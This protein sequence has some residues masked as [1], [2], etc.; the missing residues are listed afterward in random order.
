[1]HT[2]Q[3]TK[4]ALA[5]ALAEQARRLR[6]QKAACT[7]LLSDWAEAYRTIDG[8]PYNL[9]RY[10]YLRAFYD[11]PARRRCLIKGAQ[12]GATEAM[13]NLILGLMWRHEVQ[14]PGI[15]FLRPTKTEAI[16]FSTA[17]F[18]LAIDQ[19]P[20]LA[21]MFPNADSTRRTSLKIGNGVS[22]YIV[23]GNSRADLKSK[24]CGVLIVDEVDELPEE[25]EDSEQ[26]PWNPLAF[27][28][29][30]L[31]GCEDP[32]EI[33]ASTPTLPDMGIDAAYKDSNQ[34]LYWMPCPKC[35]AMQILEWPKSI[36]WDGQNPDTARFRCVKGCEYTQGEKIDAMPGGEWRARIPVHKILGLSTSQLYSPTVRPEQICE[37][38]QGAQTDLIK[39]QLFH[40]DRL[41]QGHVVKGSRLDASILNAARGSHGLTSAAGAGWR[42]T[43]GL[44]VGAV[45]HWTATNRTG[46]PH[47]VGLGTVPTL[48]DVPAL[49]AQWRPVAAVIDQAPETTKVRDFQKQFG[50]LWSCLYPP[51][52]IKDKAYRQ[53]PVT[54]RLEADRTSAL[55]MALITG[56]MQC[57]I[58]LPRQTPKDF[59]TQMCVP[60]RFTRK[61]RYGALVARW[62]KGTD[63]YA[64]AF[65]YDNLAGLLLPRY[66]AVM[67]SKRVPQGGGRVFAGTGGRVF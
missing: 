4:E 30:R 35:G 8:R 59:D 32:L 66:K 23:G 13:V 46:K 53:D 40:N 25:M 57:N 5:E 16:D 6:V 55:D 52:G 34:S 47:L 11:H 10:P 28:R 2:I 45:V 31:H 1:M 37:A 9:S 21:E 33:M 14:P 27:A 38:W 15:L 54:R 58:V 39:E 50:F 48:N 36:I 29:S 3:E 56:V 64:H 20:E 51:N 49:F 22:L 7:G 24:P 44:D 12:Q 65:A 43:M 42:V 63:H 62:S 18:D 26:R 19:S 67:P 61:D 17:R 41:G 60:T